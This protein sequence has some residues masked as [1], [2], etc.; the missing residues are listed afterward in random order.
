M[1]VL[2]RRTT[3]GVLIVCA[4]M[5]CANT[6]SAQVSA[7]YL[8][9]LSSFLGPLHYDGVRVAVDR[10]RGETFFVYQNLVRIFN[11]SG[12]E[13]FS[14]GDDLGLGQILDAAADANGDIILLS[15]K[16]G[17]TVVTRCNYRGVP[18][19]A[20][21]ITNLPPGASFRANRMILQ[22]GV[23]YFADLVSSRVVV[24]ELGGKCRQ[25]ID[26]A[27]L[28]GGETVEKA[29]A[30]MFGFAV[31]RDGS[32]YCTMPTLFKVYKLLPDGTLKYF[33]RPGSSAGR[34]GIISG[35]A[36]DS[37]GNVVVSDKLRS[38]VMAFDKDFNFLAEFGYR[39]LKPGNLSVPDDLAVD[40]Q[41][42]LYVSQGRRRGVSVFALAGQ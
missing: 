10:E 15:F 17:R 3:V 36:I 31:D 20:V 23:F 28:I 18:I 4:L 42:R 27:R 41:D 21:E 24:T 32:V 37:R 12:M 1:T 34:F 22:G 5:L 19:G 2:Q 9:T 16:D 39:G 26:F 7:K 25:V 14:F 8:Y 38:V 13:T 30:E 6:A 29:G 35:I 11:R 33:G 40:G